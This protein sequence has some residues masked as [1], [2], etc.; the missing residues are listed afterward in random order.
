M[1]QFNSVFRGPLA[2]GRV[3]TDAAPTITD[4]FNVASIT[5]VAAGNYTITLTD[6]VSTTGFIPQVCIEADQPAAAA[7]FSASLKQVS[8]TSFKLTTNS[9]AALGDV[10]NVFFSIDPRLVVR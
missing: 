10:G 6:P 3:F 2:C 5:R 1:S 8:G 9:G 7:P 4:S